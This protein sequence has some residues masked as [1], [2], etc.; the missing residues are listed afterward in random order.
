MGLFRKILGTLF[1]DLYGSSGKAIG[2]RWYFVLYTKTGTNQKAFV[3]QK[4][5][6][7]AYAHIY[8]PNTHINM[9]NEK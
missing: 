6:S 3:Y 5:Q 1:S 8:L 2:I 4:P 9:K 7:D